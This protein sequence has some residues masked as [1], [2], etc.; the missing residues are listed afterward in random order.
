MP[1]DASLRTRC[2]KFEGNNTLRVDAWVIR[3]SRLSD[4]QLQ[5]ILAEGPG[6]RRKAAQRVID[7]RTRQ[8]K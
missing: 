6:N 5:S 4:L 1:P 3:F 8:Q 2:L 7:W